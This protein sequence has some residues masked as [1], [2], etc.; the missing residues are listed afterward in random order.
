[1][2]SAKQQPSPHFSAALEDILRAVQQNYQN[3]AIWEW[4]SNCSTEA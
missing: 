2:L 4:L 1:M 3:I